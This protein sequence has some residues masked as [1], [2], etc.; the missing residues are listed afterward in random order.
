M[1]AGGGRV[2][3]MKSKGCFGDINI[4]S[5]FRGLR[6]FEAV[7]SPA[8]SESAV[9]VGTTGGGPFSGLIICVTGLSKGRLPIQY[10]L[11]S[12]NYTS[13]FLSFFLSYLSLPLLIFCIICLIHPT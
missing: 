10:H 9:V 13:Q 12:L 5:S 8:S 3:V 11:S 7:M 4:S 1:G 6:S 2:E